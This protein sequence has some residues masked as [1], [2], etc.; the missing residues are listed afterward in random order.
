MKVEFELE[1]KVV[2]GF[3]ALMLI[4]MFSLV[5]ISAT[6]PQ[7][8]IPGGTGAVSHAAEDI[9]GN[10]N[11]DTLDG[12]HAADLIGAGSSGTN[13]VQTFWGTNSCPTG[14][15][16][17]L[18]GYAYSSTHESDFGGRMFCVGQ[19][20]VPISTPVGNAHGS[21]AIVPTT[22]YSPYNQVPRCAVCYR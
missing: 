3:M 22:Q 1:K 20:W 13:Y 16:T 7:Q 17:A 15:E 12:M 4:G 8:Y 18:T 14:W 10:I 5:A 6:S 21:Y 19:N 2:I 11:A 9:S